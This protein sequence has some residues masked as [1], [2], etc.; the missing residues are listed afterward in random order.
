MSHSVERHLEVEPSSY[1]AQI[2]HFVP[3]YT[4]MIASVSEVIEQLVPP[5]AQVLDLGAGTG[6]LAHALL[7]RFPAL[8]LT[9]LDVDPEMLKQARRR[10]TPFASRVSVLEGDFSKPL[11]RAHVVVASLSMH[12]VHDPAEKIATYGR[13]RAAASLFILADAFVPESALRASVMS[14]WA[15]H[16]IAHG[17]SRAQAFARF[18]QWAQEDRYFSLEQ[19]LG[20]LRAAGFIDLDVRFRAG[21]VGVLVAR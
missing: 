9:L 4:E 1:D 17:D 19:E 5:D 18:E 15:D 10:L 2:V 6:S 3:H 21:P 20:F 8:Q 13:V 7:R 16:L 14:R 12:H 11:P